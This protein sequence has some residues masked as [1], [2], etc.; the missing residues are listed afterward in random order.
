MAIYTYHCETC[1]TEFDIRRPVAERDEPY[2]CPYDGAVTKRMMTAPQFTPGSWGDQTGKFG[3]NGIYDRGLG[4]RVQNE[5]HRDQ[6]LKKKGF[7]R[8]SEL[9]GGRETFIEDWNQKRHQE[10]EPQRKFERVFKEEI[11][12]GTSPEDAV[13]KASPATEILS[14]GD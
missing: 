10:L 3:V 11:A 1:N 7:V 5:R 6:I 12:K 2:L 14:K 9:S 8:E 13:V 4:V